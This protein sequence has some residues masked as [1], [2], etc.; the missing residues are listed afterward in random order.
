M[1]EDNLELKGTLQF[2][3]GEELVQTVHNTVVTV[4]KQYLA[5]IIAAGT[6]YAATWMQL[7]TGTNA[8]VVGDTDV[9]IA[10]GTRV[11]GTLTSSGTSFIIDSTFPAGNPA[12]Q[13]NITE[14]GIFTASTAGTMFARSVFPSVTK[15]TTDALRIVWTITVA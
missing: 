3:I 6:A 5:G 11:Q 7:G 8:V 15:P 4:G 12:T 9:Q 10:T 2:F 14:A 1:L 13:Q